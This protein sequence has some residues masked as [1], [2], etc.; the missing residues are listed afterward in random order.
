VAWRVQ[1]DKH[2]KFQYL[3]LVSCSS[4]ISVLSCWSHINDPMVE[5]VVIKYIHSWVVQ[6]PVSLTLG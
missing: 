3:F 4:S 5:I 1:H 2:E 6:K